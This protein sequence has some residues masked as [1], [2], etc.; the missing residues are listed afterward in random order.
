MDCMSTDV[1]IAQAVSFYSADQH[2]DGQADATERPT[3][4]RRLYSRRG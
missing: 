2:T 1:L 4:R 3:P